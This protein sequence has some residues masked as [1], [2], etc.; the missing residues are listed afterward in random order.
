[1]RSVVKLLLFFNFNV[2]RDF[3]FF[4]YERFLTK[5]DVYYNGQMISRQ[6]KTVFFYVDITFSSRD[7]LHT[8]DF[9]ENIM[10][11]DNYKNLVLEL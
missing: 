5:Y 7:L 11:Y 1:M 2:V 10:F 3:T 4:Y 8:M 9:M 6:F